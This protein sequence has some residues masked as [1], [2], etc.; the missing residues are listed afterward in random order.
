MPFTW[1]VISALAAASASGLVRIEEARLQVRIEVGAILLVGAVNHRRLRLRV[2]AGEQRVGE[3]GRLRQELA[4]IA[5]AA[6]KP[7]ERGVLLRRERGVREL[8]LQLR[9]NAGEKRL[10]RRPRI[11]RPAGAGGAALGAARAAAR[12]DEAVRHLIFVD[13]LGGAAHDM[14]LQR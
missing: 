8:P 3:I 2:A 1:L 13:G 6:G 11:G 14:K 7:A 4:D 5:R 10:R 9:E 12:I